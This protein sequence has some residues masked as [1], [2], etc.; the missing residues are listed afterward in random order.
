MSKGNKRRVRLSL[1]KPNLDIYI[2]IQNK[3]CSHSLEEIDI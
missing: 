1:Q 2:Q 3:L